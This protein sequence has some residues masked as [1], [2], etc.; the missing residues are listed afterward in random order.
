MISYPPLIMLLLGLIIVGIIVY[1]SI[2][3]EK[4][5]VKNG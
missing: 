5:V 4:K 2:K 3:D 1:L